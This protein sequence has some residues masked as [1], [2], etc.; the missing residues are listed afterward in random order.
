MFLIKISDT[1]KGGIQAL[2]NLC[3]FNYYKTLVVRSKS[4]EKGTHRDIGASL[5]LTL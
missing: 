2:L 4:V 3:Q 5:L 1:K